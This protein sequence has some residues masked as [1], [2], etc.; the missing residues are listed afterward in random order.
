MVD[1]YKCNRRPAKFDGLC[2]Q[3]SESHTGKITPL[4]PTN[5]SNRQTFEIFKKKFLDGDKI[6]GIFFADDAL[7]EYEYY[8]IDLK[9]TGKPHFTPLLEGSHGFGDYRVEHEKLEKWFLSQFFEIIEERIKGLDSQRVPQSELA[10]LREQFF[11]FRYII[12]QIH[13]SLQRSSLVKGIPDVNPIKLLLKKLIVKKG[14]DPAPVDNVGEIFDPGSALFFL[15]LYVTL[16]DYQLLDSIQHELVFKPLFEVKDLVRAPSVILLPWEHQLAAYE[17]WSNVGKK[18]IIVMATATGK[19]L[20]GLMAIEELARTNKRATIRIIANSRALLNQWK[21]QTVENLGLLENL[22]LDYT[23]PITWRGISVYFETIQKVIDNPENYPADLVIYDEVHHLAGPEFRKGLEIDS[24]RKMGLSATVEGEVRLSLLREALGPIVYE[25]SLKD[26]LVKGIIP[27]FEWKVIPVYLAVQEEEEF[28]SI[29]KAIA[30]QFLSIKSDY[31]TIR[32]IIG[33]DRQLED[34]GDFIRLIERA[35]SNKIDLPEG[36]KHLQALILKRRWIIHKSQPRIDDAI[37]LTRDMAKDH[38]VILFTMDTETCDYIGK[39]LEKDFNNVYVVHS[40]IRDDPSVLIQRFRHAQHGV[41]IGAQMLSE[42]IDIPD[43]EIGINVAASKTRLQLTQRMGRILRKGKEK[44]PIFYHYVAIPEPDNYIADEDD[45]AFLDDLA[46]A[47]DAALRMGLD[48]EI[49]WSEDALKVQGM[50]VESSFHKRFFGKDYSKI[51]KFG[52][53]NLKYVIS[54][55]SDQ[56][57]YR[58]TSILQQLPPDWELE[59]AQW[60][61]IVRA[62]FGKERDKPYLDAPG[63]W[64]LLILGK[65]KPVNIIE[66]FNSVKQGPVYHPDEKD[67]K[68]ISETLEDLRNLV[69]RSMM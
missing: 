61:K 38:K 28:S 37:R 2:E 57:W 36:W 59:D 31:D 66:I 44:K 12:N 22:Y 7:L 16:K 51:P 8:R 29:S 54:Q 52:T 21:R 4:I 39:I 40:Y 33:K 68:A 46:W 10:G 62:A 49:V 17:A 47:Q 56:A 23:I 18:G 26:A 6:K 9:E 24:V 30:S 1:C 15:E 20:V 48:A 50:G 53:F 42:G 58:L 45:V 13:L 60:S 27:S 14:K 64:W 34:L 43:A 65:R 25:F 19:T 35:R 41:L 55:L 11:D 5:K 67:K 63:F 3:C 32:K 69:L